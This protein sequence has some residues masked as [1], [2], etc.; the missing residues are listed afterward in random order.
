M[1]EYEE[2]RTAAA[3]KFDDLMRRNPERPSAPAQGGYDFDP[4][5]FERWRRLDA[6]NAAKAKAKAEPTP[7]PKPAPATDWAANERW[8]DEK[9]SAFVEASVGPAIEEIAN[10]VAAELDKESAAR[11]KLEDRVRELML[12]QAKAATTIA[13]LEVAFAHLEL[14]L[15]S[16]DR[17]TGAIDADPLMKTIN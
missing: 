2:Q 7:E 11:A 12:E 14:R 10:M 16:G 8:F 15:A 6:E 3:R 4:Q 13:K 9:M 17:R 1:D 5:R